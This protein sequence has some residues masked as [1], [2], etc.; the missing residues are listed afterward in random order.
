MQHT[1][2]YVL[3]LCM[4]VC[5]WERARECVKHRNCSKCSQAQKWWWEGFHAVMR[6]RWPLTSVFMCVCV[7][8]WLTSHTLL[9]W[10]LYLTCLTECTFILCV[11]CPPQ[12]PQSILSSVSPL[13]SK[14]TY[15][16]YLNIFRSLFSLLTWFHIKWRKVWWYSVQLCIAFLV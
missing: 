2:T 13:A 8:F 10:P 5:V 11:S 4:C 16:R 3:L 12:P 15:I 7:L 6:N 1:H 14:W 9:L